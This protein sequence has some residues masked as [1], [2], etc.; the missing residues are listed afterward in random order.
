MMKQAIII[1]LL[2]F[3]LILAAGARET[4]LPSKVE[5]QVP[6]LCQAPFANWAQPWQDACEEA[7]IVI[8]IHYVKAYPLDRESGNQELLGLVNYQV[9][10]YGRH[11]DLTAEQTA[12]LMADYY[13]FKKYEVVYKFNVEDIKRVLG[14]GDLV[15]APMAGR[16]LGNKY[17]HQPGPAYHFLVFKGYDD[18]SGEFITND[19]GTKR[20]DGYRYKYEVAYNAI[21]D[22]AGS[23]E[24]ITTGRK[25]MIVIRK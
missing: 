17:Y 25:V 18:A 20:G 4:A 11:H 8:A 1:T 23:K 15:L 10:K 14:A 2:A 16:L 22:W 3:T 19:P 5:L 24:N 13:K 9:K 12:K 6:F 21:H 7:A